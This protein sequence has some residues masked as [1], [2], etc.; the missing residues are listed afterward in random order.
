MT[1]YSQG[2]IPVTFVS[3]RLVPV[4][5]EEKYAEIKWHYAEPKKVGK[6][7]KIRREEIWHVIAAYK[8]A[9]KDGSCQPGRLAYGGREEP[10]FPS[11]RADDGI[12]EL[13]GEC[14]RLN[15]ED[16]ARE[17]ALHAGA[18]IG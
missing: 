16:A 3:A 1:I 8:E 15:P 4:W 17:R 7:S 11:F 12:Q 6:R 5:I 13:F 14:Y 10:V 9:S 2:Y 18:E